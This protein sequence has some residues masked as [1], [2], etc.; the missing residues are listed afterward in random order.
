MNMLP[1]PF[2]WHQNEKVSFV[3]IVGNPLDKIF[4]YCDDCEASGPAVFV[5]DIEDDIKIALAAWNA[6]GGKIE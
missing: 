1:C 2:C 4:A 3:R 5:T 6:R